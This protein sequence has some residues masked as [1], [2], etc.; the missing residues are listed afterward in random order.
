MAHPTLGLAPAAHPELDDPPAGPGVPGRRPERIPVGTTGRRLRRR[1]RRGIG[2][3]GG[4][5]H[6]GDRRPAGRPRVRGGDRP[7][8][9][10]RTA[11]CWRPGPPAASCR[12]SP[13]VFPTG[14]SR[15]PRSST[16]TP[17]SCRTAACW[18]WVRRRAV[19]RSPRNSSAPA[20]RSRLPSA[21]TSGCRGG[22]GATTSCGG[23]TRSASSTSGGTRWTTWS[24][25]Q[26]AVAATRRCS[27]HPRPQRTPGIGVR[28]VGRFAGVR[29]GV[30]QFSG[31]LTN[32]CALADL[33]LGRLLDT[34]DARAGGQGEQLEPTA[35]RRTPL[36]IDLL[37]EI[38]SI[39]WATG[40]GRTSPGWTYPC[41]TTAAGYCTTAASPAGPV[42]TCWACPCCGAAA[43][44][45]STAPARTPT[46][47]PPTSSTTSGPGKSS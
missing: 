29:D 28:L 7:G 19:C 24:G 31:S 6:H 42:C 20:G 37:G 4:H 41:S 27:P 38:R 9:L 21:T 45:T 25:P 5:P 15:S 23:W 33:K 36:G 11:S 30:A 44:H 26:P 43:R 22:T 39:V 32:V 16:A 2:R 40:V 17:T 47:W 8:P 10:A 12:P 34:I 46:T 35:V 1:V 3:A 18:S 13:G 14:S